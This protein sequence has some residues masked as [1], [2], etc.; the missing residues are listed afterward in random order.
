M[1][2][3]G[4]GTWSL[5]TLSNVFEDP[6]GILVGIQGGALTVFGVLVHNAIRIL[7]RI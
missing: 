3:A 1:F 2:F 4:A 6:N 7:N 5:W